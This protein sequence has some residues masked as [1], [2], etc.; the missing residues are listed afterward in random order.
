[1][2]QH[3]LTQRVFDTTTSSP[4]MSTIPTSLSLCTAEQ[5]ISYSEQLPRSTVLVRPPVVRAYR[6]KREASICGLTCSCCIHTILGSVTRKKKSGEEV[7]TQKEEKPETLVSSEGNEVSTQ[8]DSGNECATNGFDPTHSSM[9]S[10]NNDLQE[11]ENPTKCSD[12]NLVLKSAQDEEVHV[13]LP[14]TATVPRTEIVTKQKD[15]E[16]VHVAA[17]APRKRSLCTSTVET[18]IIFPD[19]IPGEVSATVKR[20]EGSN[21]FQRITRSM[22]SASTP[23]KEQNS[24]FA[25]ETRNRSVNKT[26]TE[27][28]STPRPRRRVLR[29]RNLNTAELNLEMKSTRSGTPLEYDQNQSE[30]DDGKSTPISL[31]EYP[32]AVVDDEVDSSA[33]EYNRISKIKQR[34][35]PSS[36]RRRRKIITMKKNRRKLPVDGLFGSP[37][38]QKI[39]VDDWIR[40][41]GGNYT[42][43][44]VLL[45]EK[46]QS[47]AEKLSTSGGIEMV[48]LGGR[49]E[50]SASYCG[51]YPA[52]YST[53]KTLYVCD[54]CFAYFSH[55]QSQLHHMI[56]CSYRWAP[57]G[58][59]IYRDRERGIS[60]FEVRGKND[61]MY[62]SNL[63]RLTMLWLENKVIFMDVEPF[64]FYVL[65]IFD[66]EGFRVLGYFSKQCTYLKHNLSCFCVFPCYQGNGYG[67]FLVDFKPSGPERPFSATGLLVYRKYWCNALIHYIYKRVL[68]VGWENLH[69]SLEE[70]ANDTGIEVQEIVQTLASLCECEWTRNNRSII[71]KITEHA[72]MEIGGRIDEQNA[73]KLLAKVEHLTPLFEQ[74]VRCNE[75]D[76]YG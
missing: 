48:D 49:Y 1:M 33:K 46:V 45:F 41:G 62:C 65:T 70:V 14:S 28:A 13:E 61:I 73:T 29:C 40:E 53:L 18:N 6:F 54:S 16:K 5:S 44:S 21:V 26:C 3:R 57:P 47:E 42:R 12:A 52:E 58:N 8:N 39:N 72:V 59:E 32:S 10:E 67:T 63:C 17:K 43:E 11:Y 24:C 25:Y 30:Q 75:E 9:L 4:A 76:E 66:G 74:N 35:P 56:K 71:V 34:V 60:V 22:T 55:Q 69:L 68:D 27:I 23:K 19:S 38:R 37:L 51:N 2:R 36:R 7:M 31:Q 20:S 15:G 50:I 64:D